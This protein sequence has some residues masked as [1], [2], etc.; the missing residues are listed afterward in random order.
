QISANSKLTAEINTLKERLA[1]YQGIEQSL[2]DALVTAEQAAKQQQEAAIRDS[3]IKVKET[4]LECEKLKARCQSEVE[5]IRK[6]ITDLKQQKARY[7]AEFRSI[8]DAHQRILASQAD[9]GAK[10]TDPDATN[11]TT[12]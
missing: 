11:S 2:R 5:E 3:E 7:L 8:V 4:E 10:T 6:E 1:T 9:G 12:D